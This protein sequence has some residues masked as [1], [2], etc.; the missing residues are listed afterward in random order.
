MPQAVP[1]HT[2]RRALLSAAPALPLLF[3]SAPALPAAV[4]PI[5]AAGA[6]IKEYRANG[7]GFAILDGDVYFG[8]H[9]P[10]DPAIKPLQGQLEGSLYHYVKAFVRE[11]HKRGVV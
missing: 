8:S 1:A 10:P 3:A 2:T 7:G 6:W 11:A 5:A 4:N 9:F